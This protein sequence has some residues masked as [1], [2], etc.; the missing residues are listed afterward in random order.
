M[1]GA[2]RTVGWVCS[3]WDD[4]PLREGCSAFHSLHS[5]TCG[6]E[7]QGASHPTPHPR[8]GRPH[9]AV[10]GHTA[11]T[12][13]GPG[14]AGALKTHTW[15][16]GKEGKNKKPTQELIASTGPLGSSSWEGNS[17]RKRAKQEVHPTPLATATEDAP[18]PPTTP[19]AYGSLTRTHPSL[20]SL[21]PTQ[22]NRQT[23]RG[24]ARRRVVNSRN[25]RSLLPP[26]IRNPQ[27]TSGFPNPPTP[28]HTHAAAA[29]YD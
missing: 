8:P 22:D 19:E 28:H 18:L 23:L 27:G 4:H 10:P 20:L 26:S 2:S 13:Q 24:A 14:R 6:V 7:A 9:Q 5:P 25:R 15:Q 16:G 21:P 1:L 12:P 3:E 29:G 17:H 11:A